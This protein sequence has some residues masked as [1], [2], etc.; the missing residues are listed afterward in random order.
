M[1]TL[2]R[3]A[4]QRSGRLSEDSELLL[5]ECGIRY[6]S[7]RGS[8]KLLTRAEDFPMEVLFLRDDDI[9]GYVADGVA[10]IGIVGLNVVSERGKEIE[11]RERL[12]FSHC[13]LALAVPKGSGKH[14]V[15][16]LQG[17]RIATS[18]PK[19]LGDFLTE[20]AIQAEIHEISGSAEIAPAIGLADAVCDL[21]SSGSTLAMNGLE[22]IE[23]IF[24]S[25]AV[26]IATPNL[27]ADKA[28]IAEQL[29]FRIRA[30]N[31]ARRLKY[32]MLNA[33]SARLDEVCKILHGSKSPTIMPLALEG[34][35]AVHVVIAENEFWGVV[36]KLRAIGAEGILVLPIEKLV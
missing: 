2:L 33:P 28:A 17:S 27:Q 23:T 25:E 10:D 24:R 26:L 36:E 31:R 3:L 1:T 16:S 5:R 14:S 35:S 8:N 15:A 13:R 4:V 32:V 29:L 6:Q 19:L 11:I 22:E 30:V 9:P 34:W 20:R 21:V 12:N 7:G 18:Y